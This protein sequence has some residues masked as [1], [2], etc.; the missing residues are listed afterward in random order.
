MYSFLLFSSFFLLFYFGQMLYVWFFLSP[1][2]LVVVC[3]LF[4][5]HFNK[6]LLFQIHWNFV[7][8]H[9]SFRFIDFF[10][11]MAWKECTIVSDQSPGWKFSIWN[12][13]QPW[14]FVQIVWKLKR[15]KHCDRIWKSLW[16]NSK[17]NSSLWQFFRKSLWEKFKEYIAESLTDWE[18]PCITPELHCFLVDDDDDDDDDNDED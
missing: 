5:I 9:F 7:M 6:S 1:L 17:E 10:I 3:Q 14:K 8:N 18:R 2:L 12:P 16:Q 11:T 15:K 4:Q 13:L